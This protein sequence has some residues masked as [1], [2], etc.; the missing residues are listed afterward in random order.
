MK[1]N[2][3]LF[4]G[5]IGGSVPKKVLNFL[6]SPGLS[7]AQGTPPKIGFDVKIKV[8]S[9]LS[10]HVCAVVCPPNTLIYAV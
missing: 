9:P 1:G 4:S 10:V 5:L 7:D 6:P 3:N 2:L 8:I